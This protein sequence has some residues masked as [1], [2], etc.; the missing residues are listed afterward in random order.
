MLRRLCLALLLA[1]ALPCGAQQIHTSRPSP[2][3]LPLPKGDDVFHFIV[4][5]DRTGGPP[6]GLDVLRQAVTDTNL[7]NP[8][9]VMNVGD[10]LPGYAGVEKWMADLADYRGIMDKL[11]MPWFPVAGNHDI[12]W[13]G[14][15]RPPGE[16]EADF[17]KHFGPLWYWFEHKKCGFIVLFTD[18]GNGTGEQ[19]DFTR[20]DMQQMSAVQMEWLRKT[21]AETKG[22]E[23]VLVFLHHP[24]WVEGTY[25]HSNWNEVHKLLAEPGNVRAI[26]AGH[27]HRLRYDGQRD[28]IE[29]ITLGTTGG[30]MPGLYPQAGFLHHMNLVT[31]RNEGAKVAVIPVGEVMDPKQFTPELIACVNKLQRTNFELTPSP[32]ALDDTGLGAGLLEFRITNPVEYPVE[33]TILPD[34]EPGE[35][36]ASAD[37]LHMVLPPKQSYQSAFTVIRTRRGFDDG[38]TVPAVEFR[39]ELLMPGLRVPLPP[40][41]ITLPVTLK[42]VSAGFF[43]TDTHKAIRLNGREAIRVEMGDKTLPEGPFTV[44]AWVNPATAGVSG[45]IVS[46]AEQSEFAINLANNVPGFHASLNGKYESAIATAGIPAGQW[47]HIAGVFDG[48]RMTL[49]VN[50]KPEATREAAGPRAT[51]PLPLYIGANPDA[52][53]KPSQFLTGAIDEVRLSRGARYPAAFTP[54]K[55]FATDDSTLYLFHCDQL[56]GPFLPSDTATP[57]YGLAETRPDLIDVR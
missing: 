30:S 28:G 18:E 53:S 13:R 11:Q 56:L 27:V 1:A 6:E 20:K 17:E 50:G 9:L 7:L 24:R 40:R 10:M 51:N 33:I 45:D 34:G 44:E 47:S 55:R 3:L 29:Y 52:A 23:N 15:G 16:H 25:P 46:K 22:L 31:V 2:K 42:S 5:G 37:H 49:Y 48:S 19:R 4:F 57:A 14:P 35:W 32:I 39:A 38:F 41:R 21:L 26:F 12:Y 43:K 54:E 36:L 8:D